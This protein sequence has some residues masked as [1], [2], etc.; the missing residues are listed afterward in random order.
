MPHWVFEDFC[1]PVESG[2]VPDVIVECGKENFSF[3]FQIGPQCPTLELSDWWR[4]LISKGRSFYYN[5]SISTLIRNPETHFL[6]LVMD[7]WW[8]NHFCRQARDKSYPIRPIFNFE[9][10]L[11]WNSAE[12]VKNC[13]QI[14]KLVWIRAFIIWLTEMSYLISVNPLFFSFLNTEYFWSVINY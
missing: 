8:R 9:A 14:L 6:V 13:V 12:I 5:L 4:D 1:D 3:L 10:T 2:K 11:V 7:F